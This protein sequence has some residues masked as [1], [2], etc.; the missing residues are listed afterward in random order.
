MI[1][2]LKRIGKHQVETISNLGIDRITVRDSANGEGK[3]F[4]LAE[5]PGPNTTGDHNTG[6]SLHDTLAFTGDGT[7]LCTR[8]RSMHQ[9]IADRNTLHSTTPF[10]PTRS[11]TRSRLQTAPVAKHSAG[12]KPKW[13]EP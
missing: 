12:S 3:N 5:G 10:R 13:I 7:P 4:T 1:E 6:L 9:Q 2:K 8:M 11:S